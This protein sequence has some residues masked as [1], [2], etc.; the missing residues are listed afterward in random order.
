[1]AATEQ[2]LAS[3]KAGRIVDAMRHA[4]A[5]RGVAGATFDHVAREARVSRGLL[6]YHFGTKERLLAE[7]VRR[8]CDLRMGLLDEQL[9]GARSA[10]DILSLLAF[11]LEELVRE[12]PEFV[13][14]VF[15]LFCLSRRNHEIAA[16]FG[17]LLRRQREHVAELLAAKQAE[18][19]LELRAEPEAVA[20]LL[21][22]LADGVAL[23]MLAEPDRDFAETVRAGLAAVRCLL[24]GAA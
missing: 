12:D 16:E 15:E 18:G 2:G 11:S 3:D 8:D 24:A 14:V 20:D 22:A 19:V 6:H 5:Q 9:A 23:R 4:V 10:E 13:T 21:F 7:V 17:E 1:M